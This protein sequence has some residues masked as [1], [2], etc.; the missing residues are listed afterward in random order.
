[1][2]GHKGNRSRIL[3]HGT[4]QPQHNLSYKVVTDLYAID[5]DPVFQRWMVKSAHRYAGIHSPAVLDTSSQFMNLAS[6]DFLTAQMTI[7]DPAVSFFYISAVI[8]GPNTY[9]LYQVV[10]T[11]CPAVML[12]GDTHA[13]MLAL[14]S[15][16]AADRPTLPV[17]TLETHLSVWETAGSKSQVVPLWHI[18]TVSKPPVDLLGI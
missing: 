7:Y 5:Y 3:Q 18:P 15:A 17:V 14:F 10:R 12:L 8:T 4:D 2:S 1:M 13:N 11:I 6:R 16:A 9:T